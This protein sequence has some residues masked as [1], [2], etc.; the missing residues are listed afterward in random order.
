MPEFLQKAI[1][2]ERDRSV[3]ARDK[4]LEELEVLRKGEVELQEAVKGTGFDE[5]S[6]EARQT[7]KE[8]GK[9][10]SALME[11]QDVADAVM[12]EAKKEGESRKVDGE[13]RERREQ[14]EELK[15]VIED[16]IA[17]NNLS[18]YVRNFTLEIGQSVAVSI[19]LE[20]VSES[21]WQK[22]FSKEERDKLLFLLG[23]FAGKHGIEGIYFDIKPIGAGKS[24]DWTSVKA[25]PVRHATE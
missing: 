9:R 15:K 19:K 24:Y 13:S 23:N 18:K 12:E 11:D 21:A 6:E 17:E 20:D 8:A 10:G 4:K 2:K 1:G 5:M 25:E 22:K 16:F 3:T 7:F 14:R